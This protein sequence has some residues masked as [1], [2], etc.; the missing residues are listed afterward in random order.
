MLINRPQSDGLTMME[1]MKGT[2]I[3]A[4]N[5]TDSNYIVDSI[6]RVLLYDGCSGSSATHRVAIDIMAAH[7]LKIRTYKRTEL[8]KP[9]KNPFFKVAKYKLQGGEKE[10]TTDELLLKAYELLNA[11][12][13][14]NNEIT[15]FKAFYESSNNLDKLDVAFAGMQRRNKLDKA[16]CYVKDCFGGAAGGLGYSVFAENGTRA[17]NLCFNR[18]QYP[19][20]KLKVHFDLRAL[21]NFIEKEK[22]RDKNRI[23]KYGQLLSPG[24]VQYYEDL[25]AFVYTS[26][27]KVFQKSVNAWASLLASMTHI[28]KHI[29]T[30]T[31]LPLK[32][33]RKDP[34]PHIESIQNYYEVINMLK[35][36]KPPVD[37][38]LRAETNN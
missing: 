38:F 12:A 36:A 15:F 35:R 16:I 19:D 21:I 29:L 33:T 24:E 26:N 20:V 5:S 31:L 25:F 1:K 13:V 28:D 17:N 22:R 2:N 9:E 34:S 27:D 4:D 7:G 14:S 8:D 18:R 6:I 37:Y 10:P 3:Q 32:N 11:N 30:N 23:L